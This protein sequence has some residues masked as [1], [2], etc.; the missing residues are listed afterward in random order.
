[1]DTDKPRLFGLKLEDWKSF[2]SGPDSANVLKLGQLTVLVGP[3]ASGKSNVL[4]ALRFL[5]GAALDLSLGE[6]LRG[7]YE[8]QREVWPGIRGGTV[9]AARSGCSSF[10]LETSWFLGVDSIDDLGRGGIVAHRLRADVS[11]DVS[12]EREGLFTGRREDNYL[13]DTHAA[14][15][16]EAT[17]RQPGGGIRAAFRAKGK[18]NSPSYTL[19]SAKSLLGQIGAKERIADVVETNANAL[20]AAYRAM[21]FLDI[22]PSRMRDYRPENGGQLG[23][24]G[25]N[26]SPA[27]YSLSQQAGRLEDVVDWLS[28]FCAPR[29]E[30]IDF[31]R[32]Q[33]REVMLFFVEV[34]GHK[35]SA[36]SLSDGTLRFLGHLVALLTCEPGTLVILEEPDAGLHPSR[37]H[38]LAELLE[39]IAKERQI[40]VLA[41]THSPTLLAHL[42]EAAFKDVVAFGRRPEDGVTICSSLRDLPQFE[43]LRQSDHLEQL[44]ST[45]WLERAL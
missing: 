10:G 43:T 36:R 30:A 33:L 23:I 14:P 37:I 28:E 4:D 1:M 15:L 17:G 45:G 11:E 7:R 42:S 6:V 26:I 25:E 3:N 24:S 41:T 22:R 19:N 40:Q 34:G 27:L 21:A 20:R 5:Q 18:G 13:F 16:R 32:T 35:I 39:R 44:I 12:L 8:G 38:L 9:E 31:D 29:I 2:G